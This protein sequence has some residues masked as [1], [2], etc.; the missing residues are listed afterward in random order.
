MKM[1]IYKEKTHLKNHIKISEKEYYK[2]ENK[3]KYEGKYDEI[4][5]EKIGKWQFYHENGELEKEQIF[6]KN[7]SES[8][9]EWDKNGNLISEEKQ[10]GFDE[11]NNV[12][13]YTKIFF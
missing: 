13:S 6:N 7:F 10:T 11:K 1:E 2:G 4:N 9:K 8:L 3:V 5:Q 12:R